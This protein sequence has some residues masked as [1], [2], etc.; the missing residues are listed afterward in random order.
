MRAERHA[1]N[2]VLHVGQQDPFVWGI[3]DA[4]WDADRK[5]LNYVPGICFLSIT[6]L[7]GNRGRSS[8]LQILAMWRQLTLY[9]GSLALCRP[10]MPCMALAFEGSQALDFSP[11]V[12]PSFSRASCLLQ[13]PLPWFFLLYATFWGKHV[14][15]YDV[16]FLPTGNTKKQESQASS[17]VTASVSVVDS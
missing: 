13:T 1:T 12:D 4:L 11:C 15:P 6:T 3:L 9:N 2:A 17:M 5:R 7:K 8:P 16:V 10:P 14:T